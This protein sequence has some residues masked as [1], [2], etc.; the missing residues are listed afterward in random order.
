VQAT[1]DDGYVEFT[2]VVADGYSLQPAKVTGS[3]A[4]GYVATLNVAV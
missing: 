4:A 2:T 3:N 1:G